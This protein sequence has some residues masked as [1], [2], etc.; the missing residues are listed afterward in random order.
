MLTQLFPLLT[1]DRRTKIKIAVTAALEITPFKFCYK[2]ITVSSKLLTNIYTSCGTYVR[3]SLKKFT[4]GN[5]LI[6]QK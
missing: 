3:N 4:S 5:K 6:N 1:F 2:N